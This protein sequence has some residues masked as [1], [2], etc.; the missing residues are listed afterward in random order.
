[1]G[2]TS[3]LASETPTV[4]QFENANEGRSYPFSDNANLESD[5]ATLPDGFFTDLHLVVPNGYSAYLSSVHISKH[6]ISACFK[7]I[8]VEREFGQFRKRFDFLLELQAKDT[9]GD[10]KDEF[11]RLVRCIREK[12]DF[13]IFRHAKESDKLKEYKEEYNGLLSDLLAL[14][15]K[16]ETAVPLDQKNTI[17]KAKEEF[18]NLARDLDFD[19]VR[20]LVTSDALEQT[21][22][23]FNK[24]LRKLKALNFRTEHSQSLS[25]IIRASDFE[26]YMPYR[27]EPLNGTHD[28]GGLVTFG[29]IDFPEEPMTY[30][31]DDIAV[32]VLDSAVARYEPAKVRGFLDPRTGEVLTGDVRLGFSTAVESKREGSGVRLDLDPTA[33]ENLLSDCDRNRPVN[34]CGATPIRSIN[35]IRSDEQKRIVIW[36]H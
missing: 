11:N 32:P 30:K 26:P 13:R 2:M 21:K 36:F 28:I 9:L 18:C 17:R 12:F 33:R 14:L 8:S 1:M 22:D 19:L 10:L 23:E 6:M 29:Q 31:F 7:A 27:L 5:G 15:I 34:T 20:E 4:L 35:G 16:L 25:V 3:I 24:L